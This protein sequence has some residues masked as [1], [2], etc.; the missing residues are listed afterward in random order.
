MQG[1]A[2]IL[3]RDESTESCGIGA[4]GR[5]IVRVVAHHDRVIVVVVSSLRLLLL[6]LLL[7][8]SLLHLLLLLVELR[9][10]SLGKDWN[11][12]ALFPHR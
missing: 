2:V 4:A 11:Y 7:L 6:E 8:H 12:H 1:G 3:L 9:F 5:D 10:D